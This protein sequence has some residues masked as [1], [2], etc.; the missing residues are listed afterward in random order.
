VRFE[1]LPLDVKAGV[2]FLRA[3]WDYKG[4]AVRA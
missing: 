1:E 3:A 4:A 2:Q